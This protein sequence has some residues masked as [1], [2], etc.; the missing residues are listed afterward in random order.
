[1]NPHALEETNELFE[2]RKG[3]VIVIRPLPREDTQKLADRTK[4]IRKA[5]EA[6]LTNLDALFGRE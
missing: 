5:R 4:K 6:S 3:G 1:V 2:E